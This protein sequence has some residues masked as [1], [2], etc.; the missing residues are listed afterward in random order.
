MNLSKSKWKEKVE[1]VRTMQTVKKHIDSPLSSQ[2]KP[3]DH[4]ECPY[5]GRSFGPK[6]FERHTEFCKEQ[7]HKL[8]LSS[9]NINS[10]AKERLK[11][12]TTVS[13]I[14]EIYVVY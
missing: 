10:E 11:V 2:V 5:C 8:R 4:E 7:Q 14:V 13:I 12:R 9:G 6:A 1:L 3:S